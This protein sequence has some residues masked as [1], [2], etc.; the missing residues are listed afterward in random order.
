MAGKGSEG[1]VLVGLTVYER[2]ENETLFS[3]SQN[4]LGPVVNP[5][6]PSII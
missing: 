5:N 6:F 3:Q 1:L 4:Q 2:R